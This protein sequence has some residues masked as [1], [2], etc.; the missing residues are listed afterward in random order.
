MEIL[1][2]TQIGDEQWDAFCD[3]SPGAWARNL[4]M[5]RRSALALD[6]RNRDFSFGVMNDGALVAIA[7][8]VT[9]PFGTSGNEFALSSS[10][11]LPAP[12]L[13]AGLTAAE[14][15]TVFAVCM[16][17]VDRLAH[18]HGVARS[19][20]SVDVFYSLALG[21]VPRENPLVRFGYLDASNT[22][23]VVDVRQDEGQLL[24]RMS[25][26]H[27][28]DIIF[29]RKQ[30]YAVDFFDSTNVTEEAWNA[31]IT[32][33]EKAAGRSVYPRARWVETFERIQNGLGLLAF[34]RDASEH[35][36]FS[37]AL[38][39]TYK[40]CA[41][42]GMAATD[43]QYRG[44]RG[45]GQFLQWRIIGELKERGFTFYDMGGQSGTSEKEVNIARFKRHFG[46][47]PVLVWTGIKTY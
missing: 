8:L 1:S 9:Q 22:T 2:F 30:T 33:Y 36:Y 19:R 12:A 15:E 7:P 29:A 28:T 13:A 3:A 10:M 37:G 41:Y 45:I 31:F 38:I 35:I 39:T 34:I 4:S 5:G 14:R 44:I 27:R 46:G 16:K 47:D 40:H 32:L 43:P 6:E 18:Q 42:Y 17:E 24:R 11:P 26:G 21:E 20:M 23:P 25:K